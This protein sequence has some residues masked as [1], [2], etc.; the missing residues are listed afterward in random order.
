MK[1]ALPANAKISKEAKETMQECVSE[2]ILFITSE[3]SDRCNTEKRKTIN[4]DDVLWAMQTLSFDSYVEP[5]RLYLQK[6]RDAEKVQLNKKTGK[7]ETVFTSGLPGAQQQ[8]LDAALSYQHHMSNPNLSQVPQPST[9]T[10]HPSLNMNILSA[11]ALSFQQRPMEI[12]QH[13]SHPPL[14]ALPYPYSAHL[15]PMQYI[16]HMKDTETAYPD[17]ALPASGDEGAPAQLGPDEDDD[18]FLSDE[19]ELEEEHLPDD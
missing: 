14:A 13:P 15:P 8:Q 19:G 18:Q 16:N 2:F 17:L 5:L 11:P 1:R 12:P 3:A 7:R 10:S 9:P 6:F 4:G